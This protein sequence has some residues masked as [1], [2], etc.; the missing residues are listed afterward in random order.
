MD[1]LECLFCGKRTPLDVFS[2]FCPD[3]REP[4]FFVRTAGKRQPPGGQ[5]ASRW[6]DGSISC[7][8][9]ASIPSWAW[10]KGIPLFVRLN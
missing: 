2:P 4:M 7:L 10:V 3:C 6:S 9:T 1:T 5:N 8:L